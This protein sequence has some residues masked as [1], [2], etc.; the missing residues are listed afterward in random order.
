MPRGRLVHVGLFEL[1]LSSFEFTHGRIWIAS[2]SVQ[3]RSGQ[4][5]SE[6]AL[7]LVALQHVRSLFEAAPIEHL[8]DLKNA[9]APAVVGVLEKSLEI[10]C[11]D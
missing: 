3:F 11:R 10:G 4:C 1:W 2:A 7:L 9:V 6:R 8:V 5:E